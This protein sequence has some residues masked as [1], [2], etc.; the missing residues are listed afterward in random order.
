MIQLLCPQCGTTLP[1]AESKIGTRIF[2][3]PKCAQPL[4]TPGPAAGVAAAPD[5][6]KPNPPSLDTSEDK[7]MAP[8]ASLQH[9]QQKLREAAA[10][11]ATQASLP[12]TEVSPPP[13]PKKK[14]A[15]PAR[16]KPGL[17]PGLLWGGIGAGAALLLGV[18][19]AVVVATRGP[20]PRAQ[21]P[22]TRVGA[23]LEQVQGP[24]PQPPLRS[25]EGKKEV[26]PQSGEGLG[27]EPD[28]LAALVQT[29]KEGPPPA[30]EKALQDLA[31]RGTKARPALAAVLDVLKG[32]DPELRG[33]A[34]ETLRRLGPA[35]PADVPA[36]AAALRDASPELRIYAAEQLAG[37]GQQAKSEL[38]FLRVLSL[39]ENPSVQEA[40]RKAVT[41][42]E[43]DLLASLVKGLRDKSAAVRGKSAQQIAEMGSNAKAALP[44]LVEALADN[45]SAVRLAVI[46]VF[47]AIGP[48]AILVL[49]EALRDKNPQV[50]LTAINAL[51]RMGPDA[52]FVLPELIAC[53]GMEVRTKEETLQALARIGDYA[54]PYLVLALEREKNVAR[55]NP[56]VEALERMGPSA[57]PALQAALKNANPEVSKA[58]APVL[59]KVKSQPPPPPP[60]D[61]VGTA[62]LIQ[63]Q[64]RG[65]F[66]SAD[67]NKD[68][69]LDKDE[70][71][72][73]I[74]GPK[75][76]AYDFTPPGKPARQFT[77]RDFP[78]YPD[79]AL[80]CR[81]D[82]D[83]DGKISRDEFERWAY[84]YADFLKKDMDERQRLAQA[85][86]RL[87]ERGLSEAMRLQREGA[88]AQLWADYYN[89]RGT[90]RVVNREF[91]K[92]EWLQRWTLHHMPR[93]R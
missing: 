15:R 55:Q 67:T 81:L 29:L 3:C 77:A 38:V 41:R 11:R 10:R 58:V 83:N 90:Q 52:R 36:Y 87:A 21:V 33:R 13:A 57:G 68:G 28:P 59:T 60:K 31:A 82:R 47:L 51:G 37:L 16:E 86:A 84:D 24:S 73:A 27:K 43:E 91:Y 75:A 63:S 18:M 5:A 19:V 78:Q 54:I 2:I 26:P 85:Q 74:R 1:V 23:A 89:V 49:G 56:L 22:E 44:S 9:V 4:K 93:P 40:A 34:Q 42:I 71:A 53:T 48:D 64:L 39:D 25:R 79:Y 69:S 92:M 8:D 72:R 50:R 46:D 30:R 88:V 70:L 66:G 61:H 17:S 45:N 76:Q 6:A 7:T 65:W 80:L 20:K 35:T 32:P 12:P 62:G 14:R